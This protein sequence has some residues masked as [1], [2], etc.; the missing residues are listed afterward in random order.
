MNQPDI[1]FYSSFTH[2]RL[3]YVVTYLFEQ[4]GLTFQWVKNEEEAYFKTPLV[5]YDSSFKN[6]KAFSIPFS[7]YLQ[8][9]RHS[10]Y[11]PSLDFGE[12][13]ML[14]KDKGESHFP[15]DIFSALFFMLARIEEYLNEQRDEHGRF[16]APNSFLFKSGL[17]RRAIVDEWILLFKKKLKERFPFLPIKSKDASFSLTMDIDQL[18]CF[19]GKGILRNTGGLVRDIITGKKEKVTKRLQVLLNRRRDPFDVY[20]ELAQRIP[21]TLQPIKAFMLRASERTK[22]E[23]NTSLKRKEEQRAIDQLKSIAEM[24]WHSSY[25]SQKN[26]DYFFHEKI[27]LEQV[28]GYKL[29]SHRSHFLRL[30]IPSTYHALVQ[31]AVKEDYTMGFARDV[32]FRAGTGHSFPFYDLSQEKTLPLILHPFS[33]MDG[34]LVDYLHLSLSEAEEILYEQWEYVRKIKGHM[35]LLV[36]NETFSDEGRWKKWKEMLFR[37]LEH[38]SKTL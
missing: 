36:H 14:F 38:I 37:F 28:L 8:L 9:P 12:I 21:H 7:G 17:H 4:L 25:Y 19:K 10:L 13:P 16:D 18:F 24:G 31:C 34:T 3:A 6:P 26:F 30:Q 1:Y 15:F 2:P 33:V 27:R 20:E 29:T 22:Y 5:I 32:G 35:T 11:I 23:K